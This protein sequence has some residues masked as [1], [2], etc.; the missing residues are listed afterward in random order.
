MAIWIHIPGVCVCVHPLCI[1]IIVRFHCH[2][3]Q[4]GSIYPVCV[5]VLH[6]IIMLSVPGTIH[7]AYVKTAD[8]RDGWYYACA[9]SNAIEGK[10]RLGGRTKLDVIPGSCK[11]SFCCCFYFF[12]LVLGVSFLPFIFLSHCRPLFV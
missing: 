11:T 3:W 12:L 4:Y 6:Y 9:M 1:V 2:S 7:F 5:C 10:I 8:D